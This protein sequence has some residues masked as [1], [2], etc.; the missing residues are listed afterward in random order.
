MEQYESVPTK[1]NSKTDKSDEA[2]RKNRKKYAN[3]F[4]PYFPQVIAVVS[5][6]QVFF[7]F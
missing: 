1:E 7:F 5:G 4:P 2:K 6:K 3:I